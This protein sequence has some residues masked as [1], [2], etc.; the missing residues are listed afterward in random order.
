[1]RCTFK[2]RGGATRFFLAL[3]FCS[4][5]KQQDARA[6]DPSVDFGCVNP[7]AAFETVVKPRCA[8]AGCHSSS[9]AASDL[10]LGSKE[11][12]RRVLSAPS[13]HCKD[14]VLLADD[15]ISGFIFEKLDDSPA[16]GS[17]MPLSASPLSPA[18]RACLHSWLYREV[19]AVAVEKK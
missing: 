4:C 15:A 7:A 1:M 6:L 8:S 11:V 18:E 17:R 13:R 10:D 12:A 5:G 16:C 19:E 9:S 2:L 3:L 14:K